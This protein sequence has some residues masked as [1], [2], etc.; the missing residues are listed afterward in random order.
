[1]SFK[2]TF[3]AAPLAAC[4]QLALE[5][6]WRAAFQL[7]GS[8]LM[9]GAAVVV[10]SY[11]L[12]GRGYFQHTV[13]AMADN[14]FEPIERSMMFYSALAQ[15]HWGALLPAALV[16]VAWLVYRKAATPLLV[17]LAV[18]LVV[19]TVAHGKV[20]SDLNYHGELS[21]LMVLVTATAIGTMLQS[22]SRI[23]AVPLVCLVV[24]TF[25]AIINHG[26]SWNRL[27]LNRMMPRPYWTAESEK[28]TADQYVAR[29]RASGGPA[30]ILDDEIA[31]RVGEPFVYDWYAL[32]L[33]FS[34]GHLSFEPL[35]QAVRGRQYTIVVLNPWQSNEWAVRLRTTA[36]ASG[37][38][39][40]RL[41]DRVEEY[42]A[43]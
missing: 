19:T 18:C 40:T 20:G 43:D 37:Y 36:L 17:Y 22:R 28:P 9:L 34:S 23:A 26:P 14:P 12:L 4:M 35:E 13:L 42:V 33:L 30:L 29:Y 24:G 6:R 2:P 32:S 16:S 41:D 39:L 7:V 21:V 27:S 1:M 5:R 15:M 11:V 3:V 38:R 10:G 25:T 8:V 31:V